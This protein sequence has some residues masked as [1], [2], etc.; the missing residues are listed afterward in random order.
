[1]TASC[2]EKKTHIYDNIYIDILC[3]VLSVVEKN[4][5]SSM[6]ESLV[7]SLISKC[8]G[9]PVSITNTLIPASARVKAATPPVAP[10]PITITS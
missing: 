5:L 10:E 3:F 2:I 6:M 8:V 9:S 1:M 7:F 4:I